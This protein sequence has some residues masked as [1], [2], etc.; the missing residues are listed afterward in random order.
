MQEFQN[1]SS[2]VVCI[3]WEFDYQIIP[4]SEKNRQFYIFVVLLI[5]I[6][7]F[8]MGCQPH[9]VQKLERYRLIFTLTVSNHCMKRLGFP[10]PHGFC[11]RNC[12]VFKLFQLQLS[13]RIPTIKH[14]VPCDVRAVVKHVYTPVSHNLTTRDTFM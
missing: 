7:R 6:I 12:L 10:F 3:C 1:K 9:I 11:K 4:K 5:H 8:Y 13:R 14:F 2:G